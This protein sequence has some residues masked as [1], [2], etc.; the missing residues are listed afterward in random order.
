[1]KNR[2]IYDKV[3]QSYKE[4]AKEFYGDYIR[5]YKVHIIYEIIDE[6]GNQGLDITDEEEE[7]ICDYVHNIYLEYDGNTN[8]SIYNIVYTINELIT[9]DKM[10]VKDILKMDIEDFCN[11]III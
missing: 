11:Q 2:E 3:L 6:I 5:Y 8:I 1:M 10:S 4:I 9:N 7:K